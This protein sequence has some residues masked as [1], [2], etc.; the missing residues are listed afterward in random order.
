MFVDTE[1]KWQLCGRRLFFFS[2][3]A[4]RNFFFLRNS[5]QFYAV[6]SRRLEEETEKLLRFIKIIS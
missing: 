3:I 2:E 4:R 1:T 5:P 6:N